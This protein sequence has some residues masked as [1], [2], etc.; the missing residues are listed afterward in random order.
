MPHVVETPATETALLP[1]GQEQPPVTL[2]T[3]THRLGP[4]IPALVVVMMVYPPLPNEKKPPLF[5]TVPEAFC[6][7]PD[8]QD[9]R[10]VTMALTVEAPAA[11]EF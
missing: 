6:Q 2:F 7:P 10:Q 11:P 1:D 4:Q 8:W 5:V 9:Y 3:L